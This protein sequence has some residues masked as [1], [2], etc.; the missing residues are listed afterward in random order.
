MRYEARLARAVAGRTVLVTGASS[1]IGRALA[2]QLAEA[3][4]RLVLVARDPARLERT[5]AEVRERGAEGLALR[6]DLA[7]RADVRALLEALRGE[8][9]DVLVNNAGLSIRRSVLRSL[10]RPEDYE[11]LVAVNYLGPLALTLGLL[12]GMLA[13][14]RGHVVNVSTIGVQ[15]G[16]PN[17]SGYVASKAALDH[18]ARS[19]LLELGRG[20]VRVTTVNMPLVRTPMTLAT[21]IYERFPALEAQQAARRI[22]RALIRRPVR[23]APA[24]TTALE[25]LHV[26]APGPMRDVF[27]LLH[28]PVHRL[29]AR[30]AKPRALRSHRPGAEEEH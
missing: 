6:A 16:A 17:F 7:D 19:L 1:G 14:R 5:L 22:G 3:G 30:R 9:V 21:E 8:A 10:D 26:L 15:A 11:R 2:H 28:D 20:P 13:R 12:P 18:F 27:A 29:L 23:V 25:L 4:A 24:W